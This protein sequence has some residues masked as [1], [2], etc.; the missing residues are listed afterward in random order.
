VAERDA[1][2]N[3]APMRRLLTYVSGRGW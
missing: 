3:P 2:T 1:L